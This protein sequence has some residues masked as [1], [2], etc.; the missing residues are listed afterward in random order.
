MS[1]DSVPRAESNLR[2]LSASNVCLQRVKMLL[3]MKEV[4]LELEERPLS[5]NKGAYKVI[6]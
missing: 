6:C 5:M 1:T 4:G 3:E 2:L